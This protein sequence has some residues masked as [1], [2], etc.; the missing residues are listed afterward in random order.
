MNF[1]FYILIYLT[2]P[3]W[4]N[5]A[6]Y[7]LLPTSETIRSGEYSCHQCAPVSSANMKIVTS[8]DDILAYHNSKVK[9][10]MFMIDPKKEPDKI[11]KVVLTDGQFIT[12]EL[13]IVPVIK[14][15]KITIEQEKEIIEGY[16]VE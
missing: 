4:N 2:D 13:K 14:K 3:C 7:T 16:K 10:T 6:V 5:C 11:Y 9:A 1:V 12:K 8:I 15:T